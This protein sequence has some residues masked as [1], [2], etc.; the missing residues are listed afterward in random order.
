MSAIKQLI[1]AKQKA[2]AKA[3][4][5]VSPWNIET[6]LFRE[7]L[8][9][10]RD[11][12]RFATAVCSVR[13][14]KSVACAADLIDTALRFNRTTGIYITLARS[15]AERIVWPELLRINREHG[16]NAIP[17]MAKLSL[18][19]PNGS[20]IYLLGANTEVEIE[21]IRGLSDVAL[22]YLDECQAFR[23]HIKELVED[24][25]VKRLYDTNGRCRMIGTPG[26][27]LSGYFYN[28]S[29]D[30]DDKGVKVEGSL[31]SHHKWTLHQ[32]PHILRKSGMT[33]EQLVAQDC[34]MRGV[35]ITHPSI[36][37]EC[38]GR[39]V[40]DPDS[41]LLN[42]NAELNHYDDLPLD[43][44]KYILGIDLGM[45]DSDS[46]T[47]L[48]YSDSTP[49]TWLVEEILTPNQKTDDLAAQIKTLEAKYGSM[50]MVADTGGLG[51]KVVTDLMYRYGFVIQKAEKAGKM[52]DYRF[53]NN[54]LRTATFMAKKHTRFAIDCNT[55]ERDDRK[56]TPD[57]IHVKGHSDAV[58]S[59]LYAFVLSPAYDYVPAKFKAAYGSSEH[60][61][62]QE[63][64]HKEAIVER[65]KREQAQKDGVY[66]APLYKDKHGR[67]PWHSWED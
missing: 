48:A 1:R 59:C 42:Y 46:L 36:Q 2:K 16:L 28:V 4:V 8:E 60:I 30:L 17:N 37:R 56:S 43:A 33:A 65:I 32:N 21:K 57:K 40:Y 45:K 14:G 55:L 34:A 9:F 54:A 22:V 7:Q 58:D 19:F 67:D 27:V 15:A 47:L 26:P 44:Y 6:F 5:I 39:W 38:F 50:T 12:A 29:N 64:L 20:T 35:S 25:V 53:L 31:W 61:K 18:V 66:N 11:P 41:L 51:L 52:A 3:S 62:E 13:A 24:I 63:K 23:P 10:V 49:V